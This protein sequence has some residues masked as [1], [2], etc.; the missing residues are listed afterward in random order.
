MSMCMVHM[1]VRVA[2][3][4][5]ALLKTIE[6]VKEMFHENAVPLSSVWVCSFA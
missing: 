2:V 6:L 4:S 5:V 1:I 3:A